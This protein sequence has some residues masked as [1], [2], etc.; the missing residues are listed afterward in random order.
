M[1]KLLQF[2]VD[3]CQLSFEFYLKFFNLILNI[4]SDPL[5]SIYQLLNGFLFHQLQLIKVI[6]IQIGFR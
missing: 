1:T 2:S 4:T 3:I 6:S 5:L